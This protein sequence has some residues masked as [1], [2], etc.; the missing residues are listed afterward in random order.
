VVTGAAHGWGALRDS[1]SGEVVLP[2]SS[3]YHTVRKSAI[4][5][6]HGSH[7]QAVVRCQTPEDV[8]QT[9]SFARRHGLH[10]VPRSGGHCFAGRSSTE[11]I[12]V[13]VSPMDSV[14]VSDD[15]V[16][17]VGAGTRLG[18]VYEVLDEHGL[19]IPAG[20]GPSVGIAGLT[21][22]GGLGVLG[23]KHGLTSDSLL[24]ARVVLADG[25]V[26]GCDGDRE[27]D[28]FWA[29]R[30]SGGGNF[31]VVTSLAFETVPAP[32]AT[33]SHLTWPH[34]PSSSRRCKARSSRSKTGISVSSLVLAYS[35]LGQ[36]PSE[37]GEAAGHLLLGQAMQDEGTGVAGLAQ[38]PHVVVVVQVALARGDH[39]AR[40][41]DVLGVG[42]DEIPAEDAEGLIQDL[43]RA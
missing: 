43:L 16:A 2:G 13:D 33:A 27:P 7:P 24:A 20:C 29:L 17:A 23:R 6:F 32:S 37:E 38:V 35:D 25:R 4:A 31:G 9:V 14:S 5:N 26:V 12:V 19:A 21:L 3:T 15:G 42:Q 36:F 40:P 41:L 39:L 1:I 30:G 10:V 18:G 28:L 22:G 11:G 34:Q 8:S